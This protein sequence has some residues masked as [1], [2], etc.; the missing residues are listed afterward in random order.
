M[1]IK[2]LQKSD[3]KD[4]TFVEGFPGVG[5]VGP[6]TISYMIDKLEMKYAGYFSS[7]EFPPMIA[8]HNGEP[9]P[10][11]RL[12]KSEK[13]KV[14]SIFSE[15]AIPFDLVNEFG[16][17]IY[18]FIKDSGIEKIISISGIPSSHVDGDNIFSIGS[19]SSM[20]KEAQSAGLKPVLNGVATGV[21]A[22]LMKNC[23]TDPD[24]DVEMLNL[25]VPVEQNIVDPKYAQLAINAINKLMGLNIDVKE[26]EKEAKEVESKLKELMQKSK[27]TK[28]NYQKTA[29]NEDTSMYG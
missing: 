20:T 21:S 10:P 27:E 26:L 13:S 9:L 11:V 6:M 12:Y 3:F 8:I 5:L 28:E 14:V 16:E 17:V 23:I 18:Q 1:E 2:L 15:F 25:L 4:Y 24:K 7:K 22:M 29:G 19:K